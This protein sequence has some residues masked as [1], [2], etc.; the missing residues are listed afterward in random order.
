MV[1]WTIF[2]LQPEKNG[3][4]ALEQKRS[5]TKIQ[6]LKRKV[7]TKIFFST[8]KLDKRL[9]F[10]TTG[11][12]KFRN[13]DSDEVSRISS[14]SRKHSRRYVVQNECLVMHQWWQCLT[15][16]VWVGTKWALYENNYQLNNNTACV[17]WHYLL[18]TGS[19]NIYE[20]RSLWSTLK[21]QGTKIQKCHW[22]LKTNN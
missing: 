2:Y 8:L 15:A 22:E 6:V 20:E 17:C 21:D 10:L 1:F 19:S 16:I 4:L 9:I 5:R 14:I 12:Q 18:T 13:N 3:Y 7:Q 11:L